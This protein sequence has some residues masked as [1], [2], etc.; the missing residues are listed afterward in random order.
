MATASSVA[1]DRK[2]KIQDPSYRN[3]CL[4]LFNLDRLLGTGARYI[5]HMQG[6]DVSTAEEQWEK[7][8][9]EVSIMDVLTE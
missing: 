2:Q 5:K 6:V 9:K 8:K 7:K 3:S 1:E 4:E